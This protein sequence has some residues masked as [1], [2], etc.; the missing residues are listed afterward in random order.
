[1][2]GEQG[3]PK[4]PDQLAWQISETALDEITN[5]PAIAIATTKISMD[6]AIQIAEFGNNSA[7]GLQGIADITGLGLGGS[8]AFNGA[9]NAPLQP[10]EVAPPPP[11]PDKIG[12]A[13]CRERV[14]QYV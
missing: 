13:S 5:N 3:V 10:I 7:G 9:G 6:E 8:N 14:C 1:M 4:A 12:R 11:P 2:N